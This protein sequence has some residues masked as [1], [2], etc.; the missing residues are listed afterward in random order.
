MTQVLVARHGE[1]DWN[2]EGRWQGQGGPGLN[3]TG[4]DQAAALAARLATVRLDAL[5]TSDLAR[6]V[7][8]AEIIAAV[9]GLVPVLEPGLREVDNGDWRG[10]TRAQVRASNPAGYRRWLNGD[11]GWHGGETYQQMHA[12]VVATLQRLLADHR[13]GRILLVSHG[14][15]VRAIVAHAVALADHDRRHIDGARNGSITTVATRRGAL[16]LVSFNDD[17]HL[18]PLR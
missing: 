16:R 12:R 6:A 2:R 8:T 10:L 14:G 7:Q 15:A 9:T 17:G 18:P 1:T 4:R 3:A 11:S 5:Y 13:R